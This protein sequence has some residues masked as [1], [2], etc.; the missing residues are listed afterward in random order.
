[1]G[2]NSTLSF[3]LKV[4][5]RW[6]KKFETRFCARIALNDFSGYTVNP[7]GSGSHRR[8]FKVLFL[9][10]ITNNLNAKPDEKLK[11]TV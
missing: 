11:F 7:N 1:M 4:E 9:P 5:L 3:S 10:S 6:T 2:S 8:L